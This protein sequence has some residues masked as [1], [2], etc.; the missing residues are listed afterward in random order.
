MLW[1][2]DI[3]ITSGQKDHILAEL[4]RIVT[5]ADEGSVCFLGDYVY[6]FSY[7]RKALLGFVDFLMELQREG[8]E[9]YVLA[10]NHDWLQGHFVYQEAQSVVK[11]LGGAGI[12]FI[13]EPEWKE[14]DGQWV[15]FF[16]WNPSLRADLGD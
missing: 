6:H 13:T 5:D 12:H 11:S 4:R 16:P 1:I 3:H 10:G 8:R 15:L 14:V 7:D 2:G 9:V